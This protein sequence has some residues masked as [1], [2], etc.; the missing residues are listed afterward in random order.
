MFACDRNLPVNI[1][2]NHAA[3]ASAHNWRRQVPDPRFFD[4]VPSFAQTSRAE[5]AASRRL[6]YADANRPDEENATSCW[7]R[8]APVLVRVEDLGLFSLI[9]IVAACATLFNMAVSVRYSPFTIRARVG[10]SGRWKAAACTLALIFHQMRGADGQ[11]NCTTGSNC[12]YGGC[13]N[14]SSQVGSYAACWNNLCYDQFTGI[15][16]PPPPACS[17]GT[18]SIDGYNGT[19]ACTFCVAGTYSLAS[20]F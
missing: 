16:C 10:H 5:K 13:N 20:W 2:V 7:T 15:L 4:C 12:E 8:K 3:P 6:I 18:W 17:S 19:F 11:Y 9:A 14:M 1:Q